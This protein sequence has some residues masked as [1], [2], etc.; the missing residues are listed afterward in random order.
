MSIVILSITDGNTALNIA[1]ENN[2]L[3]AL[4]LLCLN[5]ADINH[6]H[7]KSGFTPLR[8]AIERQA[9]DMIN[10]ILQHA[11]VNPAI[12]D[13]AGVTPLQAAM[14][15]DNSEIKNLVSEFMVSIRKFGKTATT[16]LIIIEA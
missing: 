16:L 14:T 2:N 7:K 9:F 3:K 5:G 1:I 15:K 10:Y 8:F 12:E 11:D 4:K 6:T 13:F